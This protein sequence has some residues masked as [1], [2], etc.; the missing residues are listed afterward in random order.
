MNIIM[1]MYNKKNVKHE[2]EFLWN[3]TK[4]KE[5]KKSSIERKSK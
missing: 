5:T 3:I 4:N 1:D 2:E